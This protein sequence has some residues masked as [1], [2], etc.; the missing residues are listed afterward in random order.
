MASRLTAVD[1]LD[2][3]ERGLTNPLP[4]RV[5]D[6]LVIAYPEMSFEQGKE[7]PIGRRDLYLMEVR[8]ALF[9][10]RLNCL[11]TCSSCSERLELGFDIN[12]LRA[13]P[14]NSEL[15]EIYL[16]TVDDYEVQFRLPNT[17]DLLYITELSDTTMAR[18]T[19]FERCLLQA[20]CTGELIA[21]SDVSD[22]IVNAI[23]ARMAEID[24][25]ADIQIT[26]TCPACSNQWSAAFDIASHLWIEINGWAIRI[27]EDVHRLA[28]AYGWSEAEILALSPMRRQLYLG[29]IG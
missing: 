29:M 1:L 11:T 8:E 12:Q 20:T 14:L 3:W 26:L 5:L 9:G 27:L 23:A 22:E 15:S 24:S 28:S 2:F 25:Q 16:I 4:K 18:R 6:L 10:S 19:L 21:A 7:L 17:S 13:F